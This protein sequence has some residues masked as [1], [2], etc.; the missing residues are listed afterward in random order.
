[1]V[2]SLT[3]SVEY[4]GIHLDKYLTWKHQINNVAVNVNKINAILSKI[5][6]YIDIKTLK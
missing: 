5:R 1:M 6:H 4:I 3:N 2:K